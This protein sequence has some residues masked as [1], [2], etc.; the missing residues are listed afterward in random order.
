MSRLARTVRTAA[1]GVLGLFVVWQLL[2]LLSSNLLS[3]EDAIRAA[4]R[5]SPPA[6]R[7]A[8][9]LFDGKGSTH[10]ALRIAER[11]TLRWAELTG[12]V[13]CWQLFAP[14]VADVIPFLAVELHWEDGRPPVLLL[15]ENEP[16][17]PDRFVRVGHFRLRRYETT[18]DLA[19]PPGGTPFDPRGEDWAS[20]VEQHVRA[21]AGPMLAYLRW[22]VAE[23]Q[24]RRPEL[25]PPTQ[26]VLCVRLYRVPPPPGPVPWGW[27]YLGQHRVARWL[28][29]ARVPAGDLPLE[30]YD[31]PGDGFTR[32]GR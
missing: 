28:P 2:F 3:V 11:V 16:A 13:Q 27:E 18:L 30:T 20:A 12:Q 21:E 23:F 10:S 14:D 15:S 29:G 9:D 17:G 5:K 19:P 26:V 7:V 31:P 22:R 6:Q 4:L 24:R 8:P 32:L 1:R 25:P